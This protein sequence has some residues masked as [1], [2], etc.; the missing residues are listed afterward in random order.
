MTDLWK[1]KVSFFS[2]KFW[3]KKEKKN[4]L[5]WCHFLNLILTS[6]SGMCVLTE[7]CFAFENYSPKSVSVFTVLFLSGIFSRSN[8]DDYWSW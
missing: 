2:E 7:E 4:G 6:Y 5:F 1:N 8:V 3:T